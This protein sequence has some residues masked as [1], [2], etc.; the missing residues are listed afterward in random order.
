[1]SNDNEQE[2][3][4]CANCGRPLPDP[5]APCRFCEGPDGRPDPPGAMEVFRLRRRA[6]AQ[7]LW[8]IDFWPLSLL[9]ARTAKR[10]L[11]LEE[12]SLDPDLGTLRRLRRIF[13]LALLFGGLGV[14]YMFA[15][16]LKP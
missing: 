5:L 10:G 6:R 12:A 7:L 11:A 15:R 4:P 13:V 14:A 8:G 16:L 9:A 2:P 3:L 1:M